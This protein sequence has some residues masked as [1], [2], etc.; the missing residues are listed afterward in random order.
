LVLLGWYVAVRQPPAILFVG[1]LVYTMDNDGSVADAVLLEHGLIAAVGSEANVRQKAPPDVLTIDLKGRALLP[2]FVD[3]H[4]HYPVGVIEHL[5]VQL[6]ATGEAAVVNNNELLARV[7]EAVKLTPPGQWIVGFNYD[8]TVFP[9]GLHPTRQQLDDITQ[10]HP[11]FLRH[12]SGHMGVANSAGLS[13]LQIDSQRDELIPFLGVDK[14]TGELNGL[15]QEEAA[16]HLPRFIRSFPTTDLI[17]AYKRTQADYIAAGVST[18]QNGLIDSSTS[19][20]L[21]V[22]QWVGVLPQRV[23]AWANRDYASSRKPFHTSN[24]RQATVKLIVDGSPQGKTA[25]LTEPYHVIDNGV[26]AFRGVPLFTQQALNEQVLY[27]HERDFQIALHGNGDAAIDMIIEAVRLAQ[28]AQPKPDAR[29]VLVHAQTIRSDQI[30][31]LAAVSIT[32]TFFNSH[33]FYWGDWHKNQSLGP[34]RAQSISPLA[35][36]R[37]A[38][39]RFSLHTDAPVTPMQPLQLIWSAMRRETRSGDV[40]GEEQRIDLT[41]ALR[42]MTIDAAWQS[43]LE[44][45]RGSIEPGK[46]A[47]VIVLSG[48]PYSVPDI[49]SL[50]VDQTIIGGKVFFTRH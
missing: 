13:E 2:G 12:V 50:Q 32:P 26:E 39:L 10:D 5:G 29:H 31:Q 17:S 33:T 42:A 21:R 7:S 43:F 18:V 25:Y 19:K 15:L 41:A 28:L 14:E 24:F 49:R 40:L 9:T 34:E 11:V 1:G 47:D 45:D 20:L 48:D 44:H 8:N 38:G 35:S 37:D 23:V 3:A 6:S 22:L 46:L 36:A 30:M 16:P 4:S 27:F